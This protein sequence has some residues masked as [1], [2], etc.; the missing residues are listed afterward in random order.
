MSS[1]DLSKVFSKL[2]YRRNI[3]ELSSGLMFKKDISESREAYIFILKK[4]RRATITMLF[5]FFPIDV[6][7]LNSKFEVIDIKENVKSFSLYVS[8]KGKSKYFVE[9][10]LGS[11]TKYGFKIGD[12]VLF[13]I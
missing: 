2:R 10:P 8:H 1:Y 5:V 3:F 4:E 12:R 7:W 6:L 11:I 13:P 9:M